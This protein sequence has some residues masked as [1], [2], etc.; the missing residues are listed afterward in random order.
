MDID[1]QRSGQ[2]PAVCYRCG[3]AG[4]LKRDCP[5]RFD[6]RHMTLEERDDLLDSLLAAKDVVLTEDAV[7][8]REEETPTEDFTRS[9]G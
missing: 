4:H 2:A 8:G 3:K 9:S 6:V 5:Q 1:A 7:G